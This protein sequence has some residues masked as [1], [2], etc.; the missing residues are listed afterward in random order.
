MTTAS[1][2]GEK[3]KQVQL[4]PTFEH[5]LFFFFLLIS[6]SYA[7]AHELSSKRNLKKFN[8]PK[9]FDVVRATYKK[10]GNIYES[11][12]RIGGRKVGISFLILKD[13]VKN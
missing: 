9:D 6:P 12:L 13:L 7:L 10:I 8:L 2:F 3:W 5:E 11:S 1:G 4:I